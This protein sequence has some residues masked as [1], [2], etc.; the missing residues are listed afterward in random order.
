VAGCALAAA[1]EQFTT[2]AGTLEITP[3]QHASHGDHMAPAIVD[4]LRK[5][6]HLAGRLFA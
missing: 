4:R 2:S 6:P 3:I 1:P 5:A